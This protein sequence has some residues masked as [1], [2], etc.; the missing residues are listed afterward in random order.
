[1]CDTLAQREIRLDPCVSQIEASHTS[2][3]AWESH[4]ILE[5]KRRI[6]AFGFSLLFR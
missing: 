3:N 4:E 1:L 2:Q 6:Y 5:S